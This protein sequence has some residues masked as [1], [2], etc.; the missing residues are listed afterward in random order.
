MT[1]G[2]DAASFLWRR[3]ISRVH[4]KSPHM[5][6]VFSCCSLL[7]INSRRSKHSAC[8]SRLT[9]WVIS[10]SFLGFPSASR[11]LVLS[12]RNA[13]RAASTIICSVP[14]IPSDPPSPSPSTS[15]SPCTLLS[16]STTPRSVRPQ[17]LKGSFEEN[18]RER[19]APG[20][21]DEKG[22][23]E[24][25]AA[26]APSA[27]SPADA[28]RFLLRASHPSRRR[29][30]SESMAVSFLPST[31]SVNSCYRRRKGSCLGGANFPQTARKVHTGPLASSSTIR[32]YPQRGLSRASS[33]SRNGSF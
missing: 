7:P 24:D 29:C 17:S 19:E 2:S 23:E 5:R 25:A 33:S 30:S 21:E 12:T 22:E 26:A 16:A 10:L 3:M 31:L 32:F 9:A 15:A 14:T 11:Q 27:D 13:S 18:G 20:R 4:A 6:G 8:V 1:P 28:A